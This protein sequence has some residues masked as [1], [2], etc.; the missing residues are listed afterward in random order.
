MGTKEQLGLPNKI[1]GDASAAILKSEYRQLKLIKFC[2]KVQH[3][4][5]K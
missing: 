3:E 4:E 5:I 1:V 2:R